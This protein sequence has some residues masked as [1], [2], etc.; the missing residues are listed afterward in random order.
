MFPWRSRL[1]FRGRRGLP[2]KGSKMSRTL[3][4]VGMV[5]VAA[6]P[7]MA[8]VA[9]AGEVSL[10]GWVPRSEI[11]SSVPLD[12]WAQAIQSED[13][14]VTDGWAHYVPPRT[15][16]TF[17]AV[18]DADERVEAARAGAG[19]SSE[20]MLSFLMLVV[21]MAIGGGAIYAFDH[22]HGLPATH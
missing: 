15:D 5:F 21:G 16:Q 13:S 3:K 18:A 11:S 19:L 2:G 1:L 7:L 14:Q 8:G 6:I 4:I 22:R 9:M 20:V 10:D 12:G 17:A